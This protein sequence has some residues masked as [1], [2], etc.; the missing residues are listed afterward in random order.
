M[1]LTLHKCDLDNLY[2]FFIGITPDWKI[3]TY[4]RS[5]KKCFLNISN[6]KDAREVFKII[7][8]KI[9]LE[10]DDLQKV[11]GKVVTI[12]SSTTS[13]EFSGEVLWIEAQ[14]I[15]LFATTPVIQDIESLT[16]Y[17]LSYSDFSAYSPVF[18]FFILIQAERFARKEQ[19]KSFNALEQQIAFAKLNL[20]IANFCSRCFAIDDALKFSLNSIENS[21][22]LK[23]RFEP[24]SQSSDLMDSTFED[25]IIRTPLRINEE[26][27]FILE[28]QNE[29]I[30]T[31]SESLKLF[32]RSLRF[33]LENFITKIDQYNSLQ[34][35]Q[36]SQV[37]SSRLNTLGEMAAGIAHE[38][39]NPLAI[40]QG[41][42]WV[43]LTQLQNKEELSISKLEESMNKI[44]KMTERSGKIIKGLRVFARDATEDPMEKIDLS[45]VV[46]E[47]LEL[48]KTRITHRGITLYWEPLGPH[49]AQAR[50]IQI[51]Q[52]LLN[53]LN[54][55][56]DAIE[57][58]KAP[59]I[60]ISIEP[61]D[62]FW[63][64]LVTDSGNGIPTEIQEKI[65]SPFFTTKAPGKGTGL[66]LSI[67]NSI[68]KHHNGDFWY[69]KN[70]PNTCFCFKLPILND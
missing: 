15:F 70:S 13:I 51:S 53:M 11:I 40:I 38:L 36:G 17:N 46:D 18:D 37:V 12:K 58:S 66:G 49:M 57:N 23:G 32:F 5:S 1:E 16:K 29:S 10:T 31:I 68:L 65:M 41:H 44:I 6:D 61:K 4:G 3:G 35:A 45:A 19:A 62:N 28:F 27:R 26:T 24:A 55:A 20:D 2:P 52:V 34:E 54:N 47:T 21:L 25:K 63:H 42:A 14:N 56:A 33:T 59:W 69:E 8:P 39:N 67:S 9:M 43:T 48:C 7:T 22:S 60:K 64:V 30:T 50:S